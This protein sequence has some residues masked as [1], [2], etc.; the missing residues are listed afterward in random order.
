MTVHLMCK[1]GCINI[2][3]AILDLKFFSFVIKQ[4][5]VTRNSHNAFGMY[6][7]SRADVLVIF[8]E[9]GVFC[10]FSSINLE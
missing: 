10:F 9:G 1:K 2:S 4:N 3:E 8:K 6:H 7:P 5:I